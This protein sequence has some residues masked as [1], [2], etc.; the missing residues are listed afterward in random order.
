MEWNCKIIKQESKFLIKLKSIELT[1][2]EK[3][4]KLFFRDTSSDNE[5]NIS[6]F[7]FINFELDNTLVIQVDCKKYVNENNDNVYYY[8]FPK[9]EGSVIINL[10]EKKLQLIMNYKDFQTICGNDLKYDIG[11]SW[12]STTNN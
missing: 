7:C 1:K 3:N 2:I 6:E 4:L 11:T 9:I 10:S 12:F 8:Q 5:W